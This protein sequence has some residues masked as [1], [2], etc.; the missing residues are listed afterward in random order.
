M[1]VNSRAKLVEDARRQLE[2]SRLKLAR[3]VYHHAKQP[4]DVKRLKDRLDKLGQGKACRFSQEEIKKIGKALK[5]DAGLL[6]RL[7]IDSRNGPNPGEDVISDLW[8]RV[9]RAQSESPLSPGESELAAALIAL[10]RRTGS[11]ANAIEA[12]AQLVRLVASQD[13]ETALDCVNILT[14]LANAPA[15]EMGAA[16]RLFAHIMRE[17]R[18]VNIGGAHAGE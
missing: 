7:E 8:N 16:V 5:L 11:C 12:A 17:V 18:L 3:C 10:E 15:P 14:D 4:K 1:P 13:A 6:W 2:L 9:Q